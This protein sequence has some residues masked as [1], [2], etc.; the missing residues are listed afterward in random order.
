VVVTALTLLFVSCLTLVPTPVDPGQKEFAPF[1]CL[2]GCG[3]QSLRDL[4]SNILMFIPMGWA[5]RY[6]TRW[7]G[8]LALCLIATVTIEALQTTVIGGRDASLRDI[9]SNA[10]GGALGIWLFGHWRALTQPDRGQAIR[11]AALG[12]AA[13]LA[14]LGFCG[15]GMRSAP[16]DDRWYGAWVPDMPQYARY[17]GQVLSVDAAGWTPPN[18]LIPEPVPLRDAMRRH[19]F[20]VTVRAVSGPEPRRTAAMFGVFDQGEEEQLVVGQDRFALRFHA[21]TRFEAWGLRELQ[22]RLPFFPGRA[23]G[24]TVT[25]EAGVQALAWLIRATSR[26]ERAEVR[27]P[28]TIGLG[29]TGLLPFRY[30]IWNEWVLLNAIWLAMLV[31]PVAYWIGRASPIPGFIL[32]A[33]LL[34]CGLMAAPY[35]IRAAPTTR[36][37]WVGA[38]LGALLGWGFGLFPR[39]HERPTALDD[40]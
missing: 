40:G 16:A 8:A 3:G 19:E 27:I 35:L 32:L 33:C 11:M 10:L 23:P 38:V 26:E 7:R 36:T 39:R 20:R 5:A 13:W 31:L 37:E 21:R 4:V 1:T 15:L 22:I 34:V 14:L 9:I 25:V 17:P 24:D 6:W 12:S 2:F 18:G 30:P 29:W 28:L